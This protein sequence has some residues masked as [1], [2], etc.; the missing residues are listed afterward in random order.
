MINR[1][2]LM[3]SSLAGYLAFSFREDPLV[4]SSMNKQFVPLGITFL[5][6][7][8]GFIIWN[9]LSLRFPFSHPKLVG[10]LLELLKDKG[11]ITTLNNSNL[12]MEA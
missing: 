11:W 2:Y 12:H 10:T 4:F 7:D 6:L 3:V 1:K 5:L 8:L 9:D